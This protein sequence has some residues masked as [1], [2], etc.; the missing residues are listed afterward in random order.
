MFSLEDYNYILP[1]DQIAQ[2]AIHPHHDAK[3]IV[4]EKKN[5]TI[6]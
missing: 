2:D 1:E 4:V 6:L 5:G 3:L